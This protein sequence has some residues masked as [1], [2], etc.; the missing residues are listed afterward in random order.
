MITENEDD[1]SKNYSRKPVNPRVT[2]QTAG[3]G[4]GMR[5]SVRVDLMKDDEY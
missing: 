5:D 2:L 4:G 3:F 1:D